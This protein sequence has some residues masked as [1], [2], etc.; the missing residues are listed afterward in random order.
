[1]AL[2]LDD[3][4]PAVL[5]QNLMRFAPTYRAMEAIQ[6]P[7]VHD[8]MAV[9]TKNVQ[10]DRFKRWGNRG[11]TKLARR[12]D[13]SAVIGTDSGEVLSKSTKNITIFENTGPS[14]I[15]GLPSTLHITAEDMLYARQ[16]LFQFGLQKF[17]ESIG[18]ANLADDFQCWWDSCLIEQLM[19][20]TTKYNPT[21]K[22]DNTVLV[23]DK[24]TSNDLT[25][26][27]LRLARL[28]TPRF[29]DGTYHVLASEEFMA[30]LDKD[31]GFTQFAIAIIQGG[32]VPMAA[33]PTIFGA[34]GSPSQIMGTPQQRPINPQNP[35]VYKGF[36][37]F[38][39]NNLPT[40]I[41]NAL[42]ASLALAFGPGAVGIGSGGMGP[43]V[44]TAS[45]TD[46]ERHFH[47]IWSW[48][49]DIV[50]LLDDDDSSGTCVEIR[51]Y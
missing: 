7:M 10:L 44:K 39:T 42:P 50:Y 25:D 17:H 5:G 29:P 34:Q 19:L 16:M 1:M 9:R 2:F 12:R 40:R 36:T 32:Q 26:I 30:Q 14:T 24:I 4:V 31:P 6:P 27:R 49:G 35:V 51:T 46:F 33:S 45:D 22:A 37:F 43:R 13:K 21:G 38:P 8:F 28:N 18:S 3:A 47:F 23:T 48:W 20:T 41:V 15:A 11:M